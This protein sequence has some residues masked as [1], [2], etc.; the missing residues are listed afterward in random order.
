MIVG[1]YTYGHENIKLYH[2]SENPYK[3]IIKKFCSIGEN[4]TI[5]MGGH[6]RTDWITTHP[7]GHMNKDNFN[8]YDGKNHCNFKG[9]VVIGNDVWIGMNSFIMDG[10]VIGD[11]AVIAAGSHVVKDIEPYSIYGGN[12]AKLIKYRFDKIIIDHLMQLQWWDKPT[13][14]INN[15]LKILCSTNYDRIL[16]IK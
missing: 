7:F 15:I 14:D 10:V 1:S 8:G 3:L 5:Y 12:P 2:P 6:H 9:D 13:E 11:G 16:H 4:I